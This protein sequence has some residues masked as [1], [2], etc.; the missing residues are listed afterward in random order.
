MGRQS[1]LSGSKFAQ[2]K[3]V[4]RILENVTAS[5]SPVGGQFLLGQSFLRG[6]DR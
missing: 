1:L 5:I 3:V 2:W 6:F 4:N